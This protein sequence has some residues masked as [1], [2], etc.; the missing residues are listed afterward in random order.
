[1]ELVSPLIFTFTFFSAP[2]ST[3][4]SIFSLTHPSTLLAALFFTHYVNRALISPLRTPSRS[5]SHIIVPLCAVFFNLANGYSVGA[6]L[7][8]P[9]AR[10]FLSNAYNR[11]TF[12]AGLAIWA[13]GFVGN[14]IHDEILLN[15]RRKAKAKGKMQDSNVKA[16]NG[17]SSANEDGKKERRTEHYAIPQGLLY[18]YISYPNYFCEWAEWAGF[19]LAAAPLPSLPLLVQSMSTVSFDSLFTTAFPQTL[20]PPYIFFLSQVAVMLP[21]AYRGHKWYH[22][23]FPDYPKNRTAVLPFVL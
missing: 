5:K 22:Q 1:M 17:Q 6:Y 7:S 14:I 21:R 16:R 2:L 12:Y 23:R 4:T 9:F 3:S 20:T 10:S 18:K 15:I 8:S 13:A 11:P 19:A